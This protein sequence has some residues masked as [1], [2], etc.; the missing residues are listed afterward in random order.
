MLL[1]PG[2]SLTPPRTSGEPASRRQPNPGTPRSPARRPS[3]SGTADPEAGAAG[4][5]EQAG[6]WSPGREPGPDKGQWAEG[7]WPAPYLKLY[8]LLQA[9]CPTAS[10]FNGG[11][12]FPNSPDISS[13]PP[14]CTH[15]HTHTHSPPG[16]HLTPSPQDLQLQGRGPSYESY[17][18]L[19]QYLPVCIKTLPSPRVLSKPH[20]SYTPRGRGS[21]NPAPQRPARCWA[22]PG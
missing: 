22:P 13:T 21:V 15:L 1:P 11:A 19:D 6:G 5:G 7:S 3:I 2:I 18:C 12:G 17:G 10:D 14:H 16:P 20:F 9:G 4:R 8:K